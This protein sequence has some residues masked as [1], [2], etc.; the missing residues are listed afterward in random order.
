MIGCV[1]LMELIS[2]L[3]NIAMVAMLTYK[4]QILPLNL[5]LPIACYRIKFTQMDKKLFKK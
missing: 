1:F 4:I 5:K 2:K 3:K